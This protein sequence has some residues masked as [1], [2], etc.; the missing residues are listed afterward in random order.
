MTRT[1]VSFLLFSIA[2]LAQAWAQDLNARVQILSPQVQATNKRAFDVLQQAMTDFLNNK[3][4]SNQQT[5]PEER[6]DCSFVI[7]GKESDG[8]SS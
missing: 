4:W 7:T 1:F 6:I 8:S 3:K 2:T 5:L